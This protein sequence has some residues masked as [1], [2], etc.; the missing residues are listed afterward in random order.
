MRQYSLHLAMTL[1]GSS[2]SLVRSDC[3]FVF[4]MMML[5]ELKRSD[6]AGKAALI[7]FYCVRKARRTI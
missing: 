1:P 4:A 2:R 6:Y 3:F 7:H 5:L